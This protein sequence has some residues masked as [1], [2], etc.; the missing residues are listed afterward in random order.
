MAYENFPSESGTVQ[1]PAKGPKPNLRALLTGGLLVALLGTWGYIIY[2]KNKNKETFQQQ[3]AQIDNSTAMR[4]QLQHDLDNAT[5]RFDELKTDNAKKD[6]AMVAKDREISEKKSRIQ[7]LLSKV[8]A[9]QGELAEARRLIRSLNDD[10]DGYKVQIEQLKGENLALT[11]EK[12]VITQDRDRMRREYD[13][14]QVSY[15]ATQ[16]AMKK[17]KDDVVDVASTLSASNF[18]ITPLN[19]KRNGKEKEVKNAINTDKLRISFDLGE[20]RIA[21]SGNKDIYVCIT[22]PDGNPIAVE[23]LGSGKFNTREGEEKLY[24]KKVDV[25]YTQGQRQTVNVDWKQDKFVKGSYKVEVYHNGF[26]IGE[27]LASIKRKGW[28]L[29]G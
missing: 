6:S 29:F 1:A 24:T 21:T 19:E 5:L 3:Q 13:S 18:D 16:A 20:N 11:Q 22:A 9:T 26:K 4:E 17:E 14:A 27:G 28:R 15:A 23:A 2:D 10:I 12:E 8:N 7:S 25:N